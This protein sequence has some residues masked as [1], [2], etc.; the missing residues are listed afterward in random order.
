MKESQR[1]H[2]KILNTLIKLTRGWRDKKIYLE[3]L[4]EVSGQAREERC[5]RGISLAAI[6]FVK[7]LH[8]DGDKEK[9]ERKKKIDMIEMANDWQTATEAGR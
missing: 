1:K 3:T 5:A 9:K 7:T 2:F 6:P 8:P 4:H